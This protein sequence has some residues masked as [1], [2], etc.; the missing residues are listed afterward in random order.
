[1]QTVSKKEEKE[2]IQ[3]SHDEK[4]KF[5]DML[6]SLKVIDSNDRVKSLSDC[7][8]CEYE[9]LVSKI[10][11]YNQDGEINIKLKF[12]VDKK[13]KHGIEIMG[14]VSKKSPRGIPKNSFYRDARTNG[15]YLEDPDQMKLFTNNV[16][17]FTKTDT[18]QE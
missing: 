17:P 1:M 7:I 6:L 3:M 13:T 8:E 12:K 5:K 9:E 15:L 10:T 14:E 4:L 16:K 18:T 2:K 11:E